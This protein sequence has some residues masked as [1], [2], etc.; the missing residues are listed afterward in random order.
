VLV[1]PERLIVYLFIGHS[2][3]QG[4]CGTM[5]T[6]PHPRAWVY[7][8][9]DSTFRV[10]RDPIA[11]TKSA[12]SPVMPFLKA[13]AGYYPDYYFCAVKVTRAGK[14]MTEC[15]F[16]GKPQYTPLVSALDRLGGRSVTGGLLAMFG[17][18]EGISDSLSAR[19]D[20]DAVRLIRH[21]RERC[22]ADDL[23]CLFGRYE[24][25]TDTAGSYRQ[26]L[27]YGERIRLAIERLPVVDS[28]GMTALTPQE[29]VPGALYCDDHHYGDRGYALWA[30]TA[31]DIL[32]ERQWCA[33]FDST[34]DTLPPDPPQAAR[35][36]RAGPTTA[37][38]AWLPAIDNVF[39]TTYQ[40]VV[41]AGTAA[42][43]CTSGV[44]ARDT[45]IHLSRLTP[46]TRY[47]ARVYAIDGAGNRSPSSPI[48]TF[49]TEAECG[50]APD[51]LWFTAP[52]AGHGAVAGDSVAL[53]CEWSVCTGTPQALT[54]LVS[55][56]NAHGPWQPLTGV[57]WHCSDSACLSAVSLDT[58]SWYL[59]LHDTLQDAHSAPVGPLHFT[60]PPSP[61]LVLLSP[62]G[63]ERYTPHDTIEVQW[64]Y[65]ADS[66]SALHVY[67]SA[68]SGRSWTLISGELAL[69]PADTLFGWTP[70][71]ASMDIDGQAVL[72]LVRDY[73]A[74]VEA[75]SGLVE[76]TETTRRRRRR[77]SPERSL[78][79]RIAGRSLLVS[80]P[81]T[82][83]A[84]GVTVRSMHGRRLG[85]YAI[86]AGRRC[87]AIP[88]CRLPAGVVVI[89]LAHAGHT[90]RRRVLLTD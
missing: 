5:D 76:I 69:A 7:D 29:A 87:V 17:F 68:D 39:V 54:L 67:V 88:L 31:A 71:A 9:T 34:A 57:G 41:R 14:T 56:D 18:V 43:P 77:F 61:A 51:S 63:G 74:R 48:V 36:L 37:E 90:L 25:H 22:G 8:T 28:S 60:P 59:R 24:E 70:A 26:Y 13:M 62:D 40:L 46:D 38:I 20:Q 81:H 75:M 52:S 47:E 65:N 15:F 64:A 55:R 16:P 78:R 30:Q 42:P 10:A 23:P 1:P 89:E 45:S 35:L 72:F 83:R 32:V 3:M 33:W 85:R 84:A 11:N 27:R 44:D 86:P 73:D 12:P 58:G 49:T 50:S 19:F 21:L 2:N 4:Y 66:V 79:W 80:R 82:N 53:A 6:V